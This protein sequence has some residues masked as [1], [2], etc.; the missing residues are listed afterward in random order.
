MRRLFLSQSCKI[1][2][3]F[4]T[5]SYL[6]CCFDV[7]VVFHNNY[8]LLE[9]RYCRCWQVC[10][11]AQ[12]LYSL[13]GDTLR[14]DEDPRCATWIMLHLPV[15]LQ[16]LIFF[17][18]VFCYL[19]LTMILFFSIWVYFQSVSKCCFSSVVSS[20]RSESSSFPA[21]RTAAINLAGVMHFFVVVRV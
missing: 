2:P 9:S 3:D 10:P 21:I 12:V 18:V 7:V 20:C 5:A 4:Y 1:I 15:V 17:I 8:Y 14:G 16:S 11:C 13:D 6:C 19:L